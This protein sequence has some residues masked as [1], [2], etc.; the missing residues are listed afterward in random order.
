MDKLS[1]NDRGDHSELGSRASMTV[2]DDEKD[3]ENE[4]VNC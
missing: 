4:E 1:R 3:F 2:L